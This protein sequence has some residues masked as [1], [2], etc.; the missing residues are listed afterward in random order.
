MA[1][2]ISHKI[3]RYRSQSKQDAR[4]HRQLEIVQEKAVA[5]EKI[6]TIKRSQTRNSKQERENAVTSTLALSSDALYFLEAFSV[7]VVDGQPVAGWQSIAALWRGPQVRK[8][9]IRTSP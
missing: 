1:S 6:W 9:G 8:K 5:R 2:V 7:G 3:M 4:L